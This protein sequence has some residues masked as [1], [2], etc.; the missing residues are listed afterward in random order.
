MYNQIF[1]ANFA[2]YD[3]LQGFRKNLFSICRLTFNLKNHLLIIL[4]LYV[5]YVIV[6]LCITYMYALRKENTLL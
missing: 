3:F 4:M 5:K 1:C 2:T 6:I